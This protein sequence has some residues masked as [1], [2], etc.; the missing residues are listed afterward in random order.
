MI[1]ILNKKDICFGTTQSFHGTETDKKGCASWR[2]K[3]KHTACSTDR[4]E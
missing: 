4:E 1:K 3:N 2:E